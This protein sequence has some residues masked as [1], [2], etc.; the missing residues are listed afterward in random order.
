MDGELILRRLGARK[1]ILLLQGPGSLFFHRLGGFLH[2]AGCTVTKVHFNAGDA[3]FYRHG[4]ALAYQRQLHDWPTWLAT[5][6]QER[7]IEAVIMFGDCRHYHRHAIA[8]AREQGVG[9]FVFE[10]GYVRPGFVTF[11]ADGVNANSPIPSRFTANRP[12]EV[13]AFSNRHAPIHMPVVTAAQRWLDF[14][15]MGLQ[16]AAYAVATRFGRNR[17]PHYQHHKSIRLGHEVF[18]WLRSSWRKAVYKLE[19]APRRLLLLRRMKQRYFVAPLQVFNDSQLTHHSSFADQTAF[20]SAVLHSFAAHARNDKH[21]VFKHHPMD[22]GHRYYG[23]VIDHLSREL[24][25]RGRVHYLHDVHLPTLFRHALGVITV[26][27]TAG[28]SALYHGA[29]VLCLGRSLYNLPGLT[30]QGGMDS[31]W[32]TAQTPVATE[33]LRL[34]ALLREHALVPGS[35]YRGAIADSRVAATRV[36]DRVEQGAR[37]S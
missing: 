30:H 16:A 13:S 29:P 21:L 33:V 12:S 22:R 34:R 25:L 2:D 4:N 10:E 28:L 7:G 15:A 18:C 5:V 26:N 37:Q 19:D 8:V 11:E 24:G 32:R 27:S 1:Q 17:F 20:I 14:A 3:L 31:F 6:M 23:G 9:V 36:A 35:F